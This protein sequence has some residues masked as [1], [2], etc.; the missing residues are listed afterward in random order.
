M[1]TVTIVMETVYNL[2]T[3]KVP[4]I[5]PGTENVFGIIWRNKAFKTVDDAFEALNKFIDQ[6]FAEGA[7]YLEEDEVNEIN[8]YFHDYV[9]SSNRKICPVPFKINDL[10]YMF[11]VRT[12]RVND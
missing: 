2:N 9:A 1:D 3:N 6:K 11:T 7:K 10:A 4:G 8:G 5:N 12:V